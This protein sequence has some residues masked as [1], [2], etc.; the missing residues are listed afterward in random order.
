MWKPI[1]KAP[2]GLDL[3]IAVI[4]R[5]GPHAIVFPC[6]RSLAGWV[7]SETREFIEVSPTHWRPWNNGDQI[8]AASNE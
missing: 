2:F 8:K 3:E 1:T 5:D 6:R 7:R 4:D